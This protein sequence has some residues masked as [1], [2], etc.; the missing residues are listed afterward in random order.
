LSSTY[1][2]Y[3]RSA[4][5]SMARESSVDLELSLLLRAV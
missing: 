2:A 1:A 5:E 3:G 4:L